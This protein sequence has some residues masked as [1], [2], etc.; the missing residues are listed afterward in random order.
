MV[1]EYVVN[2]HDIENVNLKPLV[3]E[4]PKVYV[5]CRE[6]S[7]IK[8]YHSYFSSWQEWA[9]SV[10]IQS[11]PATQF[12]VAL[13][14]L[15]LI[16]QDSSFPVIESSFCAINFY[17]LLLNLESPCKSPVV[18]NMLKAT[19]RIKHHKTRKKKVITVE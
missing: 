9:L 11:L 3:K 18:K 17:H 2:T 7:S 8:K 12:N 14:I 13:Y 5:Q 6:K 10:S 19:N 1:N 15:Y 16:Q 4:F